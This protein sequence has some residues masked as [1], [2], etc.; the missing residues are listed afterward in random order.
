MRDFR[1]IEPVTHQHGLFY[2]YEDIG[3]VGECQDW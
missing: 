2:L 3:K 1:R